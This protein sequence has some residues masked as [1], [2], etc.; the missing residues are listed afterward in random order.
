MV[1]HSMARPKKYN[2]AKVRSLND[3]DFF[4]LVD[5][6]IARLMARSSEVDSRLE[7]LEQ[8][9]QKQKAKPSPRKVARPSRKPPMTEDEILVD[10]YDAVQNLTHQVIELHGEQQILTIQVDRLHRSIFKSKT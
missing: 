3:D 4:Q 6:R 5:K 1:D 7:Y 8:N 9:N 10:L 2:G